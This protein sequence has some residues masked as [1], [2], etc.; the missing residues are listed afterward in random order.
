MSAIKQSLINKFK[1]SNFAHLNFDD[2][3]NLNHYLFE[4]N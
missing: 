1:D 4:I 3:E 2:L